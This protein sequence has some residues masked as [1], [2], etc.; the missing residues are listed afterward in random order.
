[1]KKY[2]YS[3]SDFHKRLL[4][5]FEKDIDGNLLKNDKIASY[6]SERLDV[7]ESAIRDSWDKGSYPTIEKIIRLIEVAGV[8]ANYLFTGKENERI[9]LDTEKEKLWEERERLY[10]ETIK[11]L[12]KKNKALED[13]FSALKQAKRKDDPDSFNPQPLRKIINLDN[14]LQR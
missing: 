14:H 12:K 8:S 3:A 9:I 13:I 5:V 1:M 11:E 10:L 7:S 4:S 6:W 2:D